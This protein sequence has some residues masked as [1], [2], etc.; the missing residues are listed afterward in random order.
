MKFL[1]TTTL[2]LILITGCRKQPDYEDSGTIF[3]FDYRKCMCC[4]GWFIR[5]DQDT[6]RF[7]QVPETCTINFDSISYPLEVWLD[8]HPK[9]PRCM[10]DE[11]IV[12]RMIEKKN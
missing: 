2:L 12:E 11:I 4:G 5:I 9:D 1:L 8:W 10:G 7:D 6:L 3:G